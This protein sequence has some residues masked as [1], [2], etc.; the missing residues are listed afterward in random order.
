MKLDEIQA[1]MEIDCIIDEINLNTSSN[2][3][4]KLVT[5]YYRIL[6]DEAKILEGIKIRVAETKKELFDYYSGYASDEYLRERPLNRKIIKS[7]IDI[8]ITSDEKMTKLQAQLQMQQ[9]KVKMIED[10]IKLLN[11]RGFTI[12]NSI[13]FLKFRN[14]GF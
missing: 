14:G 12:K 1:M 10:F 3:T 7:D 2:E 8:Y 11:Q 13:D 4:P 6:I 9:M 5:K